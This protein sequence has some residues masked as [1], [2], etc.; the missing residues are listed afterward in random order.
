MMVANNFYFLSSAPLLA[1][2]L[3]PVADLSWKR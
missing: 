2:G 3:L 1:V